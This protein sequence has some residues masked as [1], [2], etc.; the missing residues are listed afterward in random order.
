MEKKSDHW[1]FVPRVWHWW[2]L[3]FMS[4]HHCLQ[5][6]W[7]CFNLFVWKMWNYLSSFRQFCPNR[8]L[9]FNIC[10]VMLVALTLCEC[11]LIILQTSIRSKARQ[12]LRVNMPHKRFC[13]LLCSSDY[14]VFRVW[15][16]WL[17]WRRCW[18]LLT[19]FTQADQ[20]RWPV[21]LLPCLITAPDDW[22][23]NPG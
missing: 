23:F 22:I 11:S 13:A 19:P 15:S 14:T 4:R 8:V 9:H 3:S 12:A 10:T 16:C 6:V 20:Y 21:L 5:T 2:P 1:F 18:L 7:D 17:G